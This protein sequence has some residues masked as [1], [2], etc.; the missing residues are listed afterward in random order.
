MK[1]NECCDNGNSWP[2]S[3]FTSG[4][5]NDTVN[6]QLGVAFQNTIQG[7]NSVNHA[8]TSIDNTV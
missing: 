8:Y 5:G 7:N 2:I 4:A 3:W 1:D 6:N